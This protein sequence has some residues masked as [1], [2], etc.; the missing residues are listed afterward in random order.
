MAVYSGIFPWEIPWT[1]EPAELQS[2]GWQKSWL[3]LSDYTTKG[4]EILH[5]TT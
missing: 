2:L 3:R 4:N 1:G 5:A